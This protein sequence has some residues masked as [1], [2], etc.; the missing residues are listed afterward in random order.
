M[1]K[2]TSQ[3]LDKRIRRDAESIYWMKRST[4]LEV[5]EEAD[6]RKTIKQLLRDYTDSIVP[7][8]P[9]I[10]EDDDDAG[11][12]RAITTIQANAAELLGDKE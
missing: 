1:T 8:R 11:F 9:V 7:E 3:D 5:D 6:I 10:Y 12:D 2:L 4:D